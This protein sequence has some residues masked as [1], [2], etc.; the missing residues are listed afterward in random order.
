MIS[1]NSIWALSVKGNNKTRDRI[2]F[3]V[4]KYQF[5]IH[6]LL[7]QSPIQETKHLFFL[8]LSC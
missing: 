2:F 5:E 1:D 4:Q 8:I 7:I 3:M 6:H